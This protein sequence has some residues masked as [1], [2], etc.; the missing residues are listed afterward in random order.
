[1]KQRRVTEYAL[2]RGRYAVGYVIG[3]LVITAL[4]VFAAMYVPGGLREAEKVSAVASTTLEFNEFDP[5]TVVS[6]PYNIIQRGFFE[7]FGVSALS[8]KLPSVLLGLLAVIGIFY[9]VKEW[10]RK[11]VAMI[12]AIIAATMPLFVFIA[13]DGTPIVY[14]IA[15]SIW[16]LVAAT[17]T[18][19]RHTPRLLWKVVLFVLLA[20]NMYTPLGIYLNLAVVTTVVFHPHIRHLIRRLNPNYIATASLISLLLMAPLIYSLVSQPAIMMQLLGLPD[21]MPNIIENAKT[22]FLS[23]IG[24][25]PPTMALI[26][27][28]ISIGSLLLIVI[29][30]YKFVQTKHTARSYIVWF[31]IMTLIPLTFIDPN[32]VPYLFPLMVIMIAM[33]IATLISEWYK[34]FPLN[35]YARVVGLLPLSII[36]IGLLSS[37]ASRY[38]A[39]Y[40]YMPDLVKYY[41]HDLRLL[42][43]SLDVAK[44]SADEPIQL[45]L[46]EQ[47][48]A[49]YQTVAKYDD[50][51]TITTSTDQSGKY[52]I[53]HDAWRTVPI[54]QTP[55]YI[56]TDASSHDADRFYLYTPDEK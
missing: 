47:Q 53:S 5:S 3:L 21:H 23:Y 20:L 54:R 22:L 51:F 17:H 28:V 41:D 42:D 1:M 44:A 11:N 40:H 4:I 30:A 14:A 9:L 29:G 24:V 36:V 38:L 27:P 12:T 19:R 16:L 52:L 46:D 32:H 10:H 37:N 33:G 50:R 43:E 48:S 45:V 8:I 31:W 35:P 25:I 7:L 34:L 2:Y 13:Q 49:F 39:G 56:A 26:Q 6:L 15:V 18:S 55:S